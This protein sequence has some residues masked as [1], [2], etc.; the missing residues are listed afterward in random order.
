MKKL[1]LFFSLLTL[2]VMTTIPAMAAEE[3]SKTFYVT[4]NN[5][6]DTY[7]VNLDG[8][9][10]LPATPE[11]AQRSFMISGKESSYSL[12]ELK[13]E[14]GSWEGETPTITIKEEFITEA[15]LYFGFVVDQEQYDNDVYICRR[16]DGNYK[17]NITLGVTTIADAM[18][19]M[20]TRPKCPA[21]YTTD[22]NFYLWKVVTVSERK[23]DTDTTV[24]A[25][26]LN[27]R[28][29]SSISCDKFLT[30]SVLYSGI[31]ESDRNKQGF[32][33]GQYLTPR[34]YKLRVEDV[35]GNVKG[36]EY[37]TYTTMEDEFGKLSEKYKNDFGG[38]PTGYEIYIEQLYEEGGV[39]AMLVW[40]LEQD[41]E[42]M[43]VVEY[44]CAKHIAYQYDQME[45]EMSL[46][47]VMRPTYD[48]NGV[49]VGYILM[50]ESGNFLKQV[51]DGETGEMTGYEPKTNDD[52]LN[53]C[54][55]S[56]Y[57]FSYN[58]IIG[59]T[60][61]ADIE[62][63]LKDQNEGILPH[64][65]PYSKIDGWYRFY[66]NSLS[67]AL[68]GINNL[69]GYTKLSL[70]DVIPW[71][72]QDDPMY[73]DPHF[74]L[75]YVLVKGEKDITVSNSWD[76]AGMT[77]A[78]SAAVDQGYTGINV[79]IASSINF[80]DYT[81]NL[82]EEAKEA[83]F[84]SLDN[85]SLADGMS[86]IGT[87]ENPF[88]GSFT[89]EASH[90]SNYQV[91]VPG[92]L[93]NCLGAKGVVSGMT[94]ENSVIY[95]TLQNAVSD[96]TSAGKRIYAAIIADKNSGLISNVGYV[97][98][99]AVKEGDGDGIVVNTLV[100][101]NSG[102]IENC[103]F[104]NTALD[105]TSKATYIVKQT[106][107]VGR[108]KG[109]GKVKKV[110]TN[111]KSSNKS[112]P[113]F[114][115]DDEELNKAEREFTNAEFAAGPVAYWLNFD[116]DG[117]TGEYTRKWSQGGIAPVLV[118]EGQ[119]NAL[120]KLDFKSNNNTVD[121]TCD[122]AFAN[123]GDMVR[124]EFSEPV[125]SLTVDGENVMP[126]NGGLA[127]SIFVP[128]SL[129]PDI[130]IVATFAGGT[131]I[132]YIEAGFNTIAVGAYENT[133]RV[134]GAEGG[135]VMVYD[136]SGRKVMSASVDSASATLETSLSKGVYIV[137]V[138]S[139]NGEFYTKKITLK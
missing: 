19:G 12:D 29:G 28:E 136:L 121:I 76:L 129:N 97:G 38:E 56:L 120:H 24:V 83:F 7:Y 112:I 119:K 4:Y 40:P 109:S 65:A 37:V 49:E 94:L 42:E 58:G 105:E 18:N 118:A 71:E 63:A 64:V 52:S 67:S 79:Q 81:S 110:A 89:G 82:S 93:I 116:G 73:T 70:H 139:E 137:R 127:A 90:I 60:T 46:T 95:N 68:S 125:L 36:T 32:V 86:P 77:R 107:G 13:K 25:S 106:V 72:E 134:F 66:S 48:T 96:L 15:D 131:D 59:V 16:E 53:D 11:D 5:I 100:G 26:Y 133:I 92:A 130:K 44:D 128:Y 62:K 99:L 98:R 50:D 69:E 114:T 34:S 55:T 47:L 115:Y 14:L 54:F 103:F 88:Q 23:N 9:D 75:V 41:P 111:A 113:V 122:K 74:S 33:V 61:C 35:R 91:K 138:V 87:D 39:E 1:F 101:E 132:D 3:S 84:A 8:S 117:Y 126:E 45:G 80:T 27:D 108:S 51:I 104:Y 43:G 123:E 20:E 31:E 135:K 17:T 21:G 57:E 78:V 124:V 10:N 22:N 102:T 6:G 85:F 30:S 2:C